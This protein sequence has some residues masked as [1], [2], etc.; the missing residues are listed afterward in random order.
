MCTV[1]YL[2]VSTGFVLTQNRDEAP[3]RSP[4][5]ISKEKRFGTELLFPKDTKAGGTWIA[6]ARDGR[7]A[8]LLNGAF[9]KHKHEP[10]YRLSRGLVL[11]DFFRWPEPQLFFEQYDLDGIEPFTFL[12]FS[13]GKV[14]EL[15]WD[16]KTRHLKN[17]PPNQAHFWCSATLYPPPMQERRERVFRDWLTTQNLEQPRLSS[18]IFSL[19]LTGSVGDPE[20]DYVMNRAGRVCTVS[21]TQVALRSGYVRMRYADL[22]DAKHDRRSMHLLTG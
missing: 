10:P 18:R 13:P 16:G 19:H 3:T 11:L 7:T 9:E 14:T 1:T 17:L 8:C 22:L 4:Q 20:N 2:P 5:I 15:R 21:V 12:F 6:T